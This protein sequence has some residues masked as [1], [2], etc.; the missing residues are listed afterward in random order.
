MRQT[1]YLSGF[2]VAHASFLRATNLI[3]C[4][5]IQSPCLFLFPIRIG[6]S[7]TCLLSFP[8]LNRGKFI[9]EINKKRGVID[10][11]PRFRKRIPKGKHTQVLT[12]EEID[13][14]VIQS[15]N[16]ALAERREVEKSLEKFLRQVVRDQ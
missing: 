8:P 11:R 1:H 15:L 9:F 13:Q 12:L 14:L 6:T 10:D 3:F 2:F 16:T 4:P 7:P 5:A